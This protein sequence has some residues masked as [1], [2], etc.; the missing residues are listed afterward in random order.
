MGA[1]HEEAEKNASG[2]ALLRFD[3]RSYGAAV[4]FLA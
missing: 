1:Q 2:R 4:A 3:R